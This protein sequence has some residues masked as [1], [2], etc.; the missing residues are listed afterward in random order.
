MVTAALT[1]STV[2]LGDENFDIILTKNNEFAPTV[3]GAK[4]ANPVNWAY[5]ETRRL[6]VKWD[7]SNVPG[8]AL[9]A[10]V[11]AR[12]LLVYGS[13]LSALSTLD[14]TILYCDEPGTYEISCT[15]TDG[16]LT[17]TKTANVTV[18][19]PAWTAAET[20]YVDGTGTDGVQFAWAPSGAMAYRDT[21]PRA[22][23]SFDANTGRTRIVIADDQT[24]SVFGDR[25]SGSRTLVIER[26]GTGTNRPKLEI[27]SADEIGIQCDIDE[28]NRVIFKGLELF[29]TWDPVTETG[30]KPDGIR[31]LDNQSPDWLAV[32]CVFRNMFIGIHDKG[33]NLSGETPWSHTVRCSF[34]DTLQYSMLVQAPYRMGQIGNR[35]WM[36]SDSQAGG[37]NKTGVANQHGSTVRYSQP[38]EGGTIWFR[39]NDGFNNV[40]WVTGEPI[41]CQAQYRLLRGSQTGIIIRAERCTSEG[42]VGFQI[43]DETNS[44]PGWQD[45]LFDSCLHLD[46]AQG[47]GS[48]LTS[49]CSGLWARNCVSIRPDILHTTENNNGYGAAFQ[50][51][52]TG[53][54]LAGSE[55]YPCVIYG[56]LYLHCGTG[57]NEAGNPNGPLITYL[58]NTD[59]DVV[60]DNNVVYP[61]G[62]SY[63]AER[64]AMAPVTLETLFTPSYTGYQSWEFPTKDTSVATPPST[65]HILTPGSGSSLGTPEAGYRAYYDFYGNAHNGKGP[66]ATP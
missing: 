40:S 28:G 30:S 51:P 25:F 48:N 9:D 31:I 26:S 10:T 47:G 61:L 36:D 15:V 54:L 7:F 34:A 4:I 27:L 57:S 53:T 23:A 65:P 32:D 37:R 58:T 11:S 33:T 44:T 43:G 56:A 46:H 12:N 21:L 41:G 17:R 62:E 2:A 39:H 63:S 55:A 14:D 42:S 60:D 66:I 19:N 35:L 29:S 64:T 52:R 1:N 50:I 20:I 18:T 38:R 3:V 16:T 59:V 24:Y 8:Q 22:L 49:D 5:S 13:D 45:M 6:G